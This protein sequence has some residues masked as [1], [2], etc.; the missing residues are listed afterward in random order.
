MPS[1][2]HVDASVLAQ[3]VAFRGAIPA[4][5][6]WQV[7]RDVASAHV[8]HVPSQALSQQTPSTQ[9]PLLHWTSHEQARPLSLLRVP[10]SMQAF[11]ASPA[12]DLPPSLM[13]M[14]MA[15]SLVGFDGDLLQPPATARPA[16]SMTST[17][18]EP[19]SRA[20][21]CRFRPAKPK[22]IDAL[23]CSRVKFKIIQSA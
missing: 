16:A 9:K 22:V 23:P 20:P 3:S 19:R 15:A 2:P 11:G 17:R 5:M 8:T 4:T 12:S 6:G 21:S 14:S 18:Q 13:G 1:R 10:S 7:P